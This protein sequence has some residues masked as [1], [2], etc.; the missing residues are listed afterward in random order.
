[1]LFL[2]AEDFSVFLEEVLSLVSSHW[3]NILCL[4]TDLLLINPILFSYTSTFLGSS[5]SFLTF[6]LGH[7]LQNIVF[8]INF[9]MFKGMGPLSVAET[10]QESYPQREAVCLRYQGKGLSYI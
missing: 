4:F 2:I 7:Q 9:F 10:V 8:F 5:S 6:L 1:M 3:K